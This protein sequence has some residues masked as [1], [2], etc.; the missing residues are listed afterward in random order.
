MLPSSSR[1]DDTAVL[2]EIKES[3]RREGKEDNFDTFKA[4]W[5]RGGREATIAW[6]ANRAA[7]PSIAAAYNDWLVNNMDAARALLSAEPTAAS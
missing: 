5:E 7:F 2:R 6:M 1:I 3:L 4:I